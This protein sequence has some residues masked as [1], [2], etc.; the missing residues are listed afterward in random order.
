[1]SDAHELTLDSL[2]QHNGGIHV[3]ETAAH[4]IKVMGFTYL[5]HQ[6][7]IAQSHPFNCYLMP[8]CWL[9]LHSLILTAKEAPIHGTL[10][11]NNT[12]KP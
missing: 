1:M 9:L 4:Y 5:A 6:G 3:A 12:L 7:F 2:A 11:L 8:F 10:H